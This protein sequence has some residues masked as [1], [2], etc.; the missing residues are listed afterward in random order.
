VLRRPG[1]VRPAKYAVLSALILTALVCAWQTAGQVPAAADAKPL[2][3]VAD[4][5]LSSQLTWIVYGDMRFTDPA[6]TTAT[7][8][9]VRK[10]LVDRIAEERPAAVLLSGDVPWHGGISADYVQYRLETEPWRNAKIR[11]FPAL[12][13]HELNGPNPAECLNN[14][15]SAFPELRGH[16]WYSV[17]LGS[18]LA[19]LNLDSNSPLLPE[20]EQQRWIAAQLAGLPA[21]VKFVLFNLHHPPVADIQP[22]GDADHN[23][24]ANEMALA[25]MLAKSPLRGR[26]RFIVCAGHIHNYERFLRDDITYLVSGGA[27]ARPRPIQRGQDD[28]YQDPAEANYHYVKFVLHGSVIDAQMVRVADPAAPRPAWEVKDTFKIAAR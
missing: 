25:T 23:P 15:W 7:N 12:G 27:G 3:S 6:E 2:F 5:E 4:G 1:S 13:N 17:R 10:W 18:R 11:V 28:L 20:S 9:V 14:W 19:I 24:R 16:R 21:S 22:L 8:P 26:L